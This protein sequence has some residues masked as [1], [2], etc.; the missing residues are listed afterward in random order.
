[1]FSLFFTTQLLVC[2]S[3]PLLQFL[4][5][6][7]FVFSPPAAICYGFTRFIPASNIHSPVQVAIA[8]FGTQGFQFSVFRFIRSA[9]ELTV[10]A[11][12]HDWTCKL[13]GDVLTAR[14]FDVIV[15]RLV[16]IHPEHEAL[17]QGDRKVRERV[18]LA[19][20]R[21]KTALSAAP[22]AHETIRIIPDECEELV[23]LL[24][25]DFGA[26]MMAL[27]EREIRAM[28]ARAAVEA[29]HSANLT[30]RMKLAAVEVVGGTSRVPA[31]LSMLESAVA[32]CLLFC[33]PSFTLALLPLISL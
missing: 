23:T 22:S 14:L 16:Q 7:P 10:R 27:A 21:M 18:R 19:A 25:D 5:S 11:L 17:L 12:A 3:L 1:M 30:Q 13:S 28:V 2:S 24:R 8:D 9:N 4:Y 29:E 31:F 15:S 26:E 32:A 33:Y 20:E 6:P